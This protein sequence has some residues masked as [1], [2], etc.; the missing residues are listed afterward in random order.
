MTLAKHIVDRLMSLGI[1][2][3][4]KGTH[5]VTM[6]D[7]VTTRLRLEAK[8]DE[9]FDEYRRARSSSYDVSDWSYTHNASVEVPL[10]RLDPDVYRD[11][12]E[13]VFKDE[14][15]STVSI[16]RASM[17]YMFAHFDSPD[18]E[19]YF[20]N[21]VR[22]R[23]LR[24][25]SYA[26]STNILF[27]SPVCA[28]YLSAGRR[29]PTNLKQLAFERIRS[30]LAKLAIERH[31][32][33]E[34]SKPRPQPRGPN[35][36]TPHDSDWLI[37]KVVYEPNLTNYYKVAR[38]SPFPS[39]SFLA[40]YHVLEYYFLR[41][42]E[43][44]LHHQLRVSLNRTDFKANSDGLDKVIALIRRHG[45]ND[46]ETDMLRKVL[47]RFVSEEEFIAFVGNLENQ[48]GEKRYSKRRVIFGEA[49]EVSLKEGHALSNAARV[50]KQIRNAIVHS[51]DRYKRDEC[52][53]PLTESEDTIG[54]F[55]PLVKYFAEQVIYGTATPAEF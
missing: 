7:E 9:A 51:S 44:A 26:R 2:A 13:T 24:Q 49:L 52:H 10:L 36:D 20:S 33:Y 22:V 12:D 40:Y 45:S 28:T 43:D 25:V 46:D 48:G 21:I 37:P 42:A 30:C 19:R 39:Q 17:R 1:A 50:L 38:S 16:E 3:E 35:L 32:C 14:R 11:T 8:A 34:I 53:I 31:A 54:E 4:V 41:V 55:V 15:G 47:Q 23:L 29:A 5:V 6:V 27:R 18:Y